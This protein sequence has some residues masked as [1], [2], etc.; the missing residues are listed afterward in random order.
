MMRFV[1]TMLAAATVATTAWGQ[2]LPN[3]L[4][5]GRVGDGTTTL[6][7]TGNNIALLPVTLAGVAGTPIAIPS[8]GAS[9]LQVSGTAT[10][11]FA[12]ALSPAGNIISF[13]GYNPGAGGFTGS[14]SLVSRTAAQAPRGVGVVDV[15]TG[16]YGFV[17]NFTGTGTDYTGNNIRSAAT[18]DGVNFY[19]AGGV[20]GTH[21]LAGGV[22]TNIQ[23][24]N[25]NTR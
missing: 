13:T 4:V 2:I 20:Q 17:G 25:L 19:G 12:L 21:V 10:S 16:T 24:T 8:T 22:S 15:A 18:A 9:G 23:N 6:A 11:E 1:M 14:G 5:I 3:N 7:N